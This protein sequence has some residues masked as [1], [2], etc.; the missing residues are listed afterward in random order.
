ML[1][2]NIVATFKNEV[3]NIATETNL[4]ET[5]FLDGNF[6]WSTGKYYRYNTTINNPL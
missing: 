1:R 2:K 4:V 3:S 5:D 6:N